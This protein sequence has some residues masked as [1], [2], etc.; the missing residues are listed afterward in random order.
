MSNIFLLE[1][2]K[3]KFIIHSYKIKAICSL[4][5]N[6][7]K[8]YVKIPYVVIIWHKTSF[9]FLYTH[10]HVYFQFFVR[11]PIKWDIKC[12]EKTK[13][14]QQQRITVYT[15]NYAQEIHFSNERSE[16]IGNSSVLQWKIVW[17]SFK[18]SKKYI[19]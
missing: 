9:N 17:S 2:Q 8:I 4:W 18:F 16:R 11:F 1:R 19:K 3:F 14:F 13:Y 7:W 6:G 10:F 5:Q 15:R 12:K